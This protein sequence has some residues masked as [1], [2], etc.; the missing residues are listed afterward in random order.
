MGRWEPDARGRLERA[1]LELY[2]EHAYEQTTVA[3]IAERAGVSE[4]TFYRHFADKRE[5]L[6]GGDAV[7]RG[8]ADALDAVPTSVAPLDAVADALASTAD[9]FDERRPFTQ[10]RQAVIDA[11]PALRERELI[12]LASLTE[13]IGQTLRRRGV[14]EPAAALTAE[15]G[16]AVFKV[17]FAQWLADPANRSFAVHVRETLTE[18]RSVTGGS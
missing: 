1:A 18:L 8:I 5:V 2:A 9:F 3:E 17:A 6:F 14:E 15:A 12:K 13:R 10:K 16:V 11:N 7:G 4:R